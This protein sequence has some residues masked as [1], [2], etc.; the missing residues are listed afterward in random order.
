RLEVGCG[1]WLGGGTS[2]HPGRGPVASE[3]HG[4]GC[5]ARHCGSVSELTRHVA[6]PTPENSASIQ[7]AGVVKAEL[8]LRDV[9]K[10]FDLDGITAAVAGEAL[11]RSVGFCIIERVPLALNRSVVREAAAIFVLRE[12]H[13]GCSHVESLRLESGTWMGPVEGAQPPARPR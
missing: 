9:C 6:A 1:R 5:A 4:H 8:H 13:S 12:L 3:R 11:P 2:T 10:P 7:G